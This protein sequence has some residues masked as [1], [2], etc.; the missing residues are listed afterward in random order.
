MSRLF[1]LKKKNECHL[2]QILLG[3]LKVKITKKHNFFTETSISIKKGFVYTHHTIN[4]KV[5]WRLTEVNV[6]Y[7][8]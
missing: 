5:D 6:T 1:S 3:A 4:V 8:W 7:I 2:L